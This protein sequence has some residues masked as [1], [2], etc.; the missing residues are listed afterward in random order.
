MDEIT[1]GDKTYI[2]SKRAA[3]IT[4]YAKD[5]V[6]QLC[7]E[8]HIDAK[9]VGRGWYVYEPS[10]RAH[11]FGAEEVRQVEQARETSAPVG[12]QSDTATPE[13]LSTWEPPVYTSE[14]VALVPELKTPVIEEEDIPETPEDTLT[15]MQTAWKEWFDQKQTAPTPAVIEPIVENR[16]QDV[17]QYI[18][19]EAGAPETGYEDSREVS[20][21]EEVA[22]PLHRI[23][24]QLEPDE[25]IVEEEAA[26]IIPIRRV[27][28]PSAPEKIVPVQQKRKEGRKPK[29]KRERLSGRSNAPVIALFLAIALIAIVIAVIGSGY[30]DV[31]VKTLAGN[32]AIINFLVG[33]R[34][35]SR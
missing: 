20:Y 3:E 10:I 29:F 27:G 32:N 18:E 28:S 26:D 33:N 5:Y 12:S 35:F 25:E 21:A 16:N 8:G 15:D 24:T 22:V 7:R 31:Y 30:A 34:V 2:S 14:P 1:I 19:E 11:R 9:M 4:G 6:G 23:D 13:T 17:A